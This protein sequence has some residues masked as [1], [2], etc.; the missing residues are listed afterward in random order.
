MNVYKKK[1]CVNAEKR[2]FHVDV[3]R[4]LKD[5]IFRRSAE[6]WKPELN[7]LP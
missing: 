2:E 6:L 7:V 1:L 5:A 4:R 3:L